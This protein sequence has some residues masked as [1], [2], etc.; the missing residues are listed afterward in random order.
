MASETI[1]PVKRGKSAYMFF[2]A[3]ERESVIADHPDLGN[4]DI[5]R[6]LGERWTALKADSASADLLSQYQDQA[7]EDQER[8]QREK[9]LAPPAEKKPKKTKKAKKE[10]VDSDSEAEVKVVKKTAKATVAKASAAKSSG[11]AVKFVEASAEPAVKKV[12]GYIVFS[13]EQ[14]ANVK[15]E[16][17]D[18]PAAEISKELGRRWKALSTEEQAKYK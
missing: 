10:E 18:L 8:Y 14:R 9:A 13:K 4:K 6:K 17:P 1:K 3:A 16:F 12:N 2:C 11:K 5:M 15:A 7:K